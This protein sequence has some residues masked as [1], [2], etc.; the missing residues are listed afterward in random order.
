MIDSQVQLNVW[1][2]FAM[3]N[4]TL[5][6]KE[7]KRGYGEKSTEPEFAASKRRLKVSSRDEGPQEAKKAEAKLAFKKSGPG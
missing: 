2:P 4:S 3:D 6:S 5:L 7:P 1:L